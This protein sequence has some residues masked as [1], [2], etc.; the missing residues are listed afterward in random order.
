[1][2]PGNFPRY[3]DLQDL[4]PFTFSVDENGTEAG[5]GTAAPMPCALSTKVKLDH[6]F[7]FLIRAI[8]TG[9]ILFM[10]QVMDPSEG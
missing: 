4:T 6:P 9:T 7:I 10:G 1:M 3:V 8:E 2:R 5:A